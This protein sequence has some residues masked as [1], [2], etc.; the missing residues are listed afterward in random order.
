[1]KKKFFTQYFYLCLITVIF[2]ISTVGFVMVVFS[3]KLYRQEKFNEVANIGKVYTN[4]IQS[5]FEKS[6]S[7]TSTGM[8]RLNYSFNN[9]YGISLNIYDDK[10]NCVLYKNKDEKSAPI[11]EE[12]MK[13]LEAG[14]YL[15]FNTDRISKQQPQI[16]YGNRFYVQYGN[17]QPQHFY[18]LAYSSVDNIDDFT[19]S[20]FI[21]A[22]IIIAIIIIISGFIFSVTSK[23]MARPINEITRVTDKYAKGDFSEQLKISSPKELKHLAG[24][25]NEMAAFIATNDDKTKNFIAN[26]S[27]ELRTPMT[28]I[29]G[30]V[31]G[32]LDGTIQKSKQQ[33]YLVLVSQ[34]IKRLRI[35][36]TSM[37]NMT[38]FESG[39]MKPNFTEINLTD[40][41]IKTVLMFEKKIEDK[42]VEVEGLDCEKL[43]VEADADLMQQ[44]IYNLIE[45]AVKFVNT[46][47][48]ISF[49]FGK[50][51]K[52]CFASVRNTGE[53]LTDDELPKVFERFYKTDSS[54]G[55][56]TTGLGLGLSIS[57]KII[58]LHNGHII[59][60]SVHNEYTEFTIKLPIKQ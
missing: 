7:I 4:D 55:K 23:K 47:G 30:F 5:E 20:L 51:G 3:T 10:G 13:N 44:V 38:K 26:V 1:M 18:I 43:M 24:S 6:N 46:G 9:Y 50:T 39:T 22:A 42:N 31:D 33:Q 29:G 59:V 27:H 25:L 16:C 28:T 8:Q 32:I 35:L 36:V 54:R 34:E 60:K 17:E 49:S 41:V 48:V 21:A 53:G 58:H 45:N 37:L 15:D 11:S 12:M 2:T 40:T 52:E 14:E 19:N 57:R 56:D